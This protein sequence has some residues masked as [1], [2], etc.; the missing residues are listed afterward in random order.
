MN[1]ILR[2]MTI[3]NLVSRA[4]NDHPALFPS[5]S[6]RWR[7]LKNLG[8][9]SLAMSEGKPIATFLLPIPIK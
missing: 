7:T 6:E 8:P 9:S 3:M 5:S 2:Y 1:Y 4:R